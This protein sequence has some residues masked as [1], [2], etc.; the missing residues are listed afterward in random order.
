LHLALIHTADERAGLPSGSSFGRLT[1]CPASL[2]LARKAAELGQ[3]AHQ[4]SLDAERGPAIHKAYELQSARSCRLTKL[5][6]TKR[7]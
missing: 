1:K 2:L 3:L 7:S 4:T 6:L 5:P